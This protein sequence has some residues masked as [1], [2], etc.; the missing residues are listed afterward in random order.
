ML[1]NSPENI[2]VHLIFYKRYFK[3]TITVMPATRFKQKS[4]NAS[5]LMIMKI[6]YKNVTLK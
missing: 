4:N 1:P 6:R 3:D 2:H 5:E